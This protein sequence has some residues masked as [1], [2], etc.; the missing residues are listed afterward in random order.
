[1]RTNVFLQKELEESVAVADN[2]LGNIYGKWLVIDKV[3]N[4]KHKKWY[5]K[6]QCQC[7][8]KTIQILNKNDLVKGKSSKCNHCSSNTFIYHNNYI[9]GLTKKG[10]SFFFD[11]E[12]L[13]IANKCTWSINRGYVVAR[14][15]GQ[16]FRFHREIVNNSPLSYA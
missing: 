3:F 2:I 6:C 7:N 5:Y 1:M 4:S 10:E 8:K 14:K 15:G 13:D 9:E 16:S 12:D 11:I